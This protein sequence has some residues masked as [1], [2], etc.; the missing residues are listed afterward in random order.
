MRTKGLE[1]DDGDSQPMRPPA[2]RTTSSSNTLACCGVSTTTSMVAV[3][4]VEQ[5]PEQ[6]PPIRSAVH[7][8]AP[9]HN[10]SNDDDNTDQSSMDPEQF[11]AKAFMAAIG[12][13]RTNGNLYSETTPPPGAV[14][15]DGIHSQTFS[16]IA[17][18]NEWNNVGESSVLEYDDEYDNE[19]DQNNIDHDHDHSR[20]PIVAQLAPDEN[21]V[22]ARVAEGLEHQMREEWT[23]RLKQEVEFHATFRDHA[24][25]RFKCRQYL[26]S[27]GHIFRYVIAPDRS[28]LTRERGDLL[29]R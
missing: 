20:S 5:A 22:A 21:D 19:D 2:R 28:Q 29:G 18:A 10:T 27:S 3:A 1:A 11:R 4:P 26:G 17:P 6:A 12:S 23:E 24:R 25:L 16:G 13:T 8:M 7:R 14:A 15:V 9:N